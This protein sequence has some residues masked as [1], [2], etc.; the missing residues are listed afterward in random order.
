[1]LS[2]NKTSSQSFIKTKL[3]QPLKKSC[4][5]N[6]TNPVFFSHLLSWKSQYGNKMGCAKQL[7]CNSNTT[8]EVV[9]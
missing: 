9:I 2:D 6:F 5:S 1:M 3:V 7:H 4:R 8:Y